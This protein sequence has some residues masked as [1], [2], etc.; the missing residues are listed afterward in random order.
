MICMDIGNDETVVV[1]VS[2]L[3]VPKDE[4]ESHTLLFP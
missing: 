1:V 3:Q 4:E 2:M